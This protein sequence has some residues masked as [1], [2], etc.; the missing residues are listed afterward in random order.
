MESGPESGPDFDARNSN[1]SVIGNRK[2]R[3][4]ADMANDRSNSL[5]TGMPQLGHEKPKA[6]GIQRQNLATADDAFG[7]NR[8]AAQIAKELTL[9]DGPMWH[10]NRTGVA[11]YAGFLSLITGSLGKIG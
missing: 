4:K 3:S 1:G 10:T 2:E 11:A 5:S 9:I 6:V 8:L 7:Y